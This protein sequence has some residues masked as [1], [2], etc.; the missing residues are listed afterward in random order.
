MTCRLLPNH[1]LILSMDY[2]YPLEA[3]YTLRF[4][5]IR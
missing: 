2:D 3:R 4:A 1:R 5:A